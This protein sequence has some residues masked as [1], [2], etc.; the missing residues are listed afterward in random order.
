M[1]AKFARSWALVKAS[2]GVLKQDKELLVF[3]AISAVA[4]W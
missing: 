3:P 2:A 4:S 1:F